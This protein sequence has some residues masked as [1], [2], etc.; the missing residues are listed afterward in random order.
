MRSS[1]LFQLCVFLLGA[2]GSLIPS[3]NDAGRRCVT[4][5]GQHFHVRSHETGLREIAGVRGAI[6]RTGRVLAER[7][8]TFRK[9]PTIT[10][11]GD[12]AEYVRYAGGTAFRSLGRAFRSDVFLLAPR[13]WR[14]ACL[15]HDDDLDALLHHELMHVV[16]EQSIEMP[17]GRRPHFPLWFNEGYADTFS[18]AHQRGK[19]PRLEGLA[20]RIAHLELDPILEFDALVRKDIRFAYALVTEAMTDLVAEKGRDL[21]TAVFARMRTGA[22]FEAAFAEVTGE[23]QEAFAARF[24][25]RVY[26][27]LAC[28]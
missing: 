9:P 18:D 16:A 5:A 12:E 10:I 13:L 23:T 25:Q 27:M 8:T 1:K 6:Q 2:L 17:D 11:Y 15:L 24:S 20:D 19:H 7:H 28:E 4:I 26:S 14:R 21:P 22:P 3:D